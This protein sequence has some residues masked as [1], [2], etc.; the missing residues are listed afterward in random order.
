MTTEGWLLKQEDGQGIPLPPSVVDWDYQRDLELECTVEVDLDAARASAALP[1]DAEL[2]LTT[3]WNSSGSGLRMLAAEERLTGGGRRS[4]H[5]AFTVLGRDSGG[6]LSIDTQVVLAGNL[7]NPDPTG[8]RRAGSIL[9][10]HHAQVRLQ[11]D[12][13]Q[14]PMAVV[15]FA[16]AG[17]PEDAPWYLDIGPNLDAATMGAVLLLVN[18]RTTLVLD[19][20]RK[21]EKATH[22]ERLIQSALRQ[23][24]VRLMIEHA[25]DDEDLDDGSTFEPDTLGHM[26]LGAVRT[27]LPDTTLAALRLMRRS[28]PSYFSARVQ[29]A[30]GLFAKET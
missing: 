22:A 7:D 17:Y 5:L 20:M 26:L 25:V 6:V 4:V 10:Q 27:H 14:F 15:D 12:A 24:V 2:A 1:E 13:S 30:V 3:V 18:S 23:D 8:P 19:A 21:A 11:G 29:S 16:E 9:W 28:D